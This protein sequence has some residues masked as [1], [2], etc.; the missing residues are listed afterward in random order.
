MPRSRLVIIRMLIKIWRGIRKTTH[1]QLTIILREDGALPVLSL[2]SK[3]K[4][5]K[6]PQT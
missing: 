1:D 4:N 5:T 3:V 6:V 2:A